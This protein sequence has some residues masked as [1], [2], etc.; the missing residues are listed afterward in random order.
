MKK[1]YEKAQR[2]GMEP[3]RDQREAAE[4]A[5]QE[6]IQNQRDFADSLQEHIALQ[7]MLKQQQ[8]EKEQYDDQFV[9]GLDI[10][11]N[12]KYSGPTQEQVRRELAEQIREREYLKQREYENQYAYE[13]DEAPEYEQDQKQAYGKKASYGPTGGEKV[14]IFGNPAFVAG[15]SS[16]AKENVALDIFGNPVRQPSQKSSK[17]LNYDVDIFGNPSKRR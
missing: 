15:K 3:V 1:A 5:K 8:R 6:K 2:R 16:N 7:N 11:G 12:Y 14:D 13:R 17:P 4:L 9:T 10:K